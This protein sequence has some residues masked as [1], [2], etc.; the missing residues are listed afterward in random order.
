VDATWTWSP[1]A[2]SSRTDFEAVNKDIID[3]LIDE[4]AGPA[5]K[6]VFR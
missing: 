1:S 5:D 3:A 6:G 2:V 4:F